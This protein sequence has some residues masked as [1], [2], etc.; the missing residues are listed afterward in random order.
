MGDGARYGSGDYF[1]S[2]WRVTKGAVRPTAGFL[3]WAAEL[4]A[5]KAALPPGGVAPRG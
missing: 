3:P 4:G 2:G 5:A 1:L